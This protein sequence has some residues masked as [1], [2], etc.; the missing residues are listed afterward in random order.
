MSGTFGLG[1]AS[2]L[3]VAVDQA[4]V[5]L[6][7]VIFEGH[8]VPSRIGVGGAHAVTIHRLPGGG[9]IVD[10]M[11]VDDSAISW[12]GFFTGPFAATR[13]R[14]VDSI[15]QSGE[16]VELSFGD[17][18]F[19]VVVVHF[20]YDLQDRGA[21]IA[22]RIRTETIPDTV[23]QL[24]DSEADT[25]SS[26][27][28]DIA[29]ATTAL[30]GFGLTSSQAAL[31]SVT[32]AIALPGPSTSPGNLA[33]VGLAVQAAGIV[34]QSIVIASAK[35]LPAAGDSRT[36]G[37]AT[38]RGLIAATAAA[39]SLAAATQAIGYVNRSRVSLNQLAGRPYGAPPIL[40]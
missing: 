6:G 37:V 7:S 11:G 29:S 33:T 26:L 23:A 14:L 9:R 22:Y 30:S 40:A 10:A 28:A 17:Y 18:A 36:L 1:I 27:S 13:A 19:N 34:V 24:D 4:P 38:S 2:A 15:R 21:L 5:V 16:M 25:A 35:S 12:A 3:M 20:E 32:S 31:S 8:E 39:G